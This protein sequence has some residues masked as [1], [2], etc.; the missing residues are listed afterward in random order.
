MG[1]S[2]WAAAATEGG[3]VEVQAVP[4]QASDFILLVLALAVLVLVV[5]KWI[6]KALSRR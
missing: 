2:V 5:P 1:S 3:T 6:F 4:L